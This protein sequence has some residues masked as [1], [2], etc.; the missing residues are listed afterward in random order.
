VLIGSADVQSFADMANV[1][2]NVRQARLIPFG[3]A[4]I[5]R[6]AAATAA[7]LLPLAL[8]IFSVPELV[9]LLVKIV[10]K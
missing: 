6:L 9:K 10:F 3:S 5:A 7:P 1:Y 2:S 8:T 4:D